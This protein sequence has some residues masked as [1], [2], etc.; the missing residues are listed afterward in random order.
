MLKNCVFC[1]I[2]KKKLSIINESK[3]FFIIRDNYPVTK[4]HTL[5]ISKR[6]ITSFFLLKKDEVLN[7]FNL[8][9]D[10]KDKLIKKDRKIKG[11]NIGIND[12]KCAGQTIFHL[13]IHLIP[14]R[15]MDVKKPKG[16][17]RGIIPNKQNY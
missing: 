5:F 7:L 15:K 1:K 17:V 10:Q 9:N 13:H 11:F 2:Q 3:F 14:R 16:G 12:G 8:L 4:F 6:H